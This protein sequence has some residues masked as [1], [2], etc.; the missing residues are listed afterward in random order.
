ED[1]RG[2][3]VGVSSANGNFKSL[4]FCYTT[5]ENSD[6]AIFTIWLLTA[7]VRSI[8]PDVNPQT[9]MNDLTAANSSGTVV[10]GGVKFLIAEDGNLNILTATVP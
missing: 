5:P 1:Y 4:S 10:A 7:F 6:E 3:L 2:A 8:S 9:L